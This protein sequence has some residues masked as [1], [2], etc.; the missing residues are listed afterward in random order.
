MS[1]LMYPKNTLSLITSVMNCIM[2][3]FSFHSLIYSNRNSPPLR[4]GLTTGGKL[5]GVTIEG[6]AG[7]GGVGIV[8]GPPVSTI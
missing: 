4:N 8:I 7:G 6:G 2:N 1:N 3:L 5:T